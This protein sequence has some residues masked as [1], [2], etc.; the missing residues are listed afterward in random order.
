MITAIPV[1]TGIQIVNDIG[2]Y[3]NNHIRP[4]ASN[5]NILAFGKALNNLQFRAPAERFVKQQRFELKNEA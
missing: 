3:T 5:E 2:R 1:R 4:N